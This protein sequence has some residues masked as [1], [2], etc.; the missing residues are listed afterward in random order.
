MRHLPLLAA[1]LL[2][3][4]LAAQVVVTRN[5]D[6]V[7]V[8]AGG[9]P[10]TALCTDANFPYLYPLLST[11][12]GDVTRHFP[13]RKGVANEPSD[14]PHH[15]SCWVA[16]GDVNGV[17]FWQGEGRITVEEILAADG[18]AQQGTL[19]LALAWK[20]KQDLVLLSETRTYTFSQPDAHTRVVVVD[21]EFKAVAETVSF[22][23]TKEGTF[24]L[25]LTPT[26][27]LTGKGAGGKA[28]NSEGDANAKV[29]GKRAAWVAFSGTD[30]QQRPLIVMIADH[31]DNPRHPTWWHARDYGLFAAN[32]FGVHD[33]QPDM[34]AGTGTLKLAKGE[35]ARFRHRI[36]LYAGAAD[37]AALAKLA[38]WP[39]P[40]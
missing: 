23:E 38:A 5:G 24:A 21:C 15:R 3:T 18:G 39:K 22:G 34:P 30:A 26:L 10:F 12:G 2:V 25:R 13:M 11:D 29:W 40:N 16:H 14:H 37:A 28:T 8:E 7:S 9:K 19:K 27:Q 32:P 35:T 31:P 6:S 33:F 1:A 17:D 20:T 4:P 36:V